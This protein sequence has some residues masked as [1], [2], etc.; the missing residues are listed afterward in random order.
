MNKKGLLKVKISNKMIFSCELL[1]IEKHC[2]FL[3]QGQTLVF[4]KISAVSLEYKFIFLF[5]RFKSVL[6][7][8]LCR[9]AFLESKQTISTS[10][11]S[12]IATQKKWTQDFSK[13]KNYLWN[14]F[15]NSSKFLI[16]ILSRKKLSQFSLALRVKKSLSSECFLYFYLLPKKDLPCLMGKGKWNPNHFDEAIISQAFV[17]F[18]YCFCSL[19]T[20]EKKRIKNKDF[21][22]YENLV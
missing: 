7:I 2:E 11:I 14:S 17:H 1:L 15:F 21:L 6:E 10:L 9:I 8:R 3:V 19:L 20:S 13:I 22:Y 5:V 12:S 16:Q 18:Q 4:G